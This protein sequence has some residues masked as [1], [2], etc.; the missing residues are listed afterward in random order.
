MGTSNYSDAFKRNGVQRIPVRGYPAREVSQRLGMS[1]HTLYQWMRLFTA[2]ALK[3]PSP[4]HEAKN[5]RPKRELAWVTE[6]RD[7]LKKVSHGSPPVQEPCRTR[8]SRAGPNGVCVHPLTSK[9]GSRN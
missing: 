7:I 9:F 6:E 3:M 5:R 8:P 4:A 2:P 1:S